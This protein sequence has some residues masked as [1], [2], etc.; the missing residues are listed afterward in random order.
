MTKIPS[1]LIKM[2]FYFMFEIWH[3]DE[4]YMMN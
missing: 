3:S 1:N 2:I 4:H